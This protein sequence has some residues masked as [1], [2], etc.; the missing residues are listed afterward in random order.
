MPLSL[1]TL[2]YGV[3]FP[4]AAKS[5]VNGP[6]T[7]PVYK[8]LKE[9]KGVE[10]IEWNFDVFLIDKE[11]NV[12]E[13]FGRQAG[14]V[15]VCLCVCWAPLADLVDPTLRMSLS[16]LLRSSS[17]SISGTMAHACETGVIVL[18]KISNWNRK[19]WSEMLR[20]RSLS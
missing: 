17:D 2:N 20:E 7:N 9:Q 12:A 3:T 8:Y 1:S 18:M 15:S 16:P 5:D 13:Y 14:T 6:E 11:G 10:N 19:R 4:L